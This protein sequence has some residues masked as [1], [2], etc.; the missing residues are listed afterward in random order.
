MLGEMGVLAFGSCAD[1]QAHLDDLLDAA[2]RDQPVVVHDG[3]RSFAV[4]DAERLRSLL[5]RACPAIPRVVAEPDGSS[6]LIPGLPLAADGTSLDEAL[7]AMVEVLR[8]YA[9]DWQNHLR[10]A[11]N[12]RDNWALVQLVGLSDDQQLKEWLVAGA[13]Q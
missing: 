13:G 1:A 11:P 10:A 6:V 8:E 2:D 7:D 4:V 5:A 12:H 9:D 3:G